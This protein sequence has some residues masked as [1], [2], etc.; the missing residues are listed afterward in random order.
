[1]VQQTVYSPG[2][3]LIV[4]GDWGSQIPRLRA[5]EG[6]KFVK[7][8]HRPPFP[9]EI[10]QVLISVKV[11]IDTRDIVRPEGLYKWKVPMASSGIEP[12]TFRL[13]AQCLSQLHHRLIHLFRANT[14]TTTGN[15]NV[16][17]YIYIYIYIYIQVVPGGKDLTSGEC[18]L[19]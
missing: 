10:P 16:C 3:A 9:Q 14:I 6:Y 4:S 11:W 12:S 7:P 5:H 17:I 1:M 8:R 15:R 19:C 18:S 2:Q 13:I